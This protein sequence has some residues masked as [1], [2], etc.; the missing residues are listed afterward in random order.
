M[1]TGIRYDKE[2][3]LGAVKQVIEEGRSVKDVAAG[4]GLHENTVYSWVNVAKK[5]GQ[6]KAFPGSGV[7]RDAEDEIKR[8]KQFGF[9]LQET[10]TV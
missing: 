7:P 4:L 5:H 1:A 6:A 9:D 2:L 8:A 3:K 10:S